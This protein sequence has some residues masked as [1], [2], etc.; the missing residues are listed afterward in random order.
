MFREP[1][2][3]ENQDE[4]DMRVKVALFEDKRR[5]SKDRD[6]D[7]QYNSERRNFRERGLRYK[8]SSK[9][10]HAKIWGDTED[11]SAF[12]G[13]SKRSLETRTKVSKDK[14][15]MK[16]RF[17]TGTQGRDKREKAL[18]ALTD[19]YAGS[20]PRRKDDKKRIRHTSDPYMRVFRGKNIP[21]NVLFSMLIEGMPAATGGKS[22]KGYKTV[23]N[24]IDDRGLMASLRWHMKYPADQDIRKEL[25]KAG[26]EPNPGPCV[27]IECTSECVKFAKK[28]NLYAITYWCTLCGAPVVASVGGNPTTH[29]LVKRREEKRTHPIYLAV[30][31]DGNRI[32]GHDIDKFED[33]EFATA[34]KTCLRERPKAPT[35]I[36]PA[37]LDLAPTPVSAP[38]APQAP[39]PNIPKSSSVPI[40]KEEKRA[41][42]ITRTVKKPKPVFDDL[43]KDKVTGES[44]VAKSQETTSGPVKQKRVYKPSEPVEYDRSEGEAEVDLEEEEERLFD[45]DSADGTK[46][47]LQAFLRDVSARTGANTEMLQ[48]KLDVFTGTVQQFINDP[49]VNVRIRHILSL[50]K[51][52]VM[53]KAQERY[54]RALFGKPRSNG[55]SEDITDPEALDGYR[56]DSREAEEY[57]RDKHGC[58]NCVTDLLY[59]PY[60]AEKRLLPDRPVRE[61]KKAFYMQ[62][63]K[64][65][66][67][68]DNVRYFRW[69]WLMILK[70]L[71][72]CR[73][74]NTS[75][76][77]LP[78]YIYT[79]YTT[80]ATVWSVTTIWF[81]VVFGF[82][83]TPFIFLVLL[84]TSKTWDLLFRDKVRQL[85]EYIVHRMVQANLFCDKE[86]LYIPHI[87]STILAETP[88]NCS[89]DILEANVTAKFNRNAGFPIPD[90]WRTQLQEG[91]QSLTVWLKHHNSFFD[92]LASRDIAQIGVLMS[93]T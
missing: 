80:L 73:N 76:V 14:A 15:A 19:A 49:S 12:A 29:L 11:K 4:L 81:I 20:V 72:I 40:T 62:R 88:P 89:D 34:R 23:K 64:G 3:Q 31:M 22:E 56:I 93:S 30:T 45:L 16:H 65:V 25:L 87:A 50:V 69:F 46:V 39:S 17:K 60:E 6:L 90:R 47:K 51:L 67:L 74:H 8:Q 18:V 24:L 70:L 28:K 66:G 7:K 21:A 13:N 86:V 84:L 9:Q 1:S 68:S 5:W 33:D 55:A 79:F 77:T 63:L 44:E 83:G 41:L 82:F 38:V 59:I 71:F 91:T 43:M 54:A 92:Q 53:S 42:K 52:G 26:I 35:F 75:L 36:N 57:M 10:K 27:S 32:D 85:I 2:A 58:Q 37:Q 78:L 48:H 61:E